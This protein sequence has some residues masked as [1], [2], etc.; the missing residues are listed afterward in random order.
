M[1]WWRK[2]ITYIALIQEGNEVVF[3]S[4]RKSLTLQLFSMLSSV[5]LDPAYFLLN[6]QKFP[7][8]L[9]TL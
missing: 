5:L 4:G 7:P 3:R 9:L 1:C 8:L 6:Y 2:L